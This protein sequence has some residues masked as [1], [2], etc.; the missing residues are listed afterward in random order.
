M[1]VSYGNPWPI[2]QTKCSPICVCCLIVKLN[3]RQM[4]HLYSSKLFILLQ[5]TNIISSYENTGKF[6]YSVLKILAYFVVLLF[7]ILCLFIPMLRQPLIYYFLSCRLSID[8]MSCVCGHSLIIPTSS[9]C[10][11]WP[12]QITVMYLQPRPLVGKSCHN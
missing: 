5:L 4:Y 3:V 2:R 1:E 6:T 11:L 7:R 10:W 8:Y 9:P 12:L